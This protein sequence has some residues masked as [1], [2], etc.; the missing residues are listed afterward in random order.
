VFV[1]NGAPRSYDFK[2]VTLLD[3]VIAYD[4]RNEPRIIAPNVIETVAD[5]VRSPR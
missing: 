1:V 5:T 2:D 4:G 3:F